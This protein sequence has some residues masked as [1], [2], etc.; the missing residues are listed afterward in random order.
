MSGIKLV[1]IGGHFEFCEMEKIV[2]TFS[3]PQNLSL[4]YITRLAFSRRS[5]NGVR[6]G[7]SLRRPHDLNAWNRLLLGKCS[8]LSIVFRLSQTPSPYPWSRLSSRS[9][10]SWPQNSKW[11]PKKFHLSIKVACVAGVRKGRE[12]EL[13]PPRS[14]TP[15]ISPFPSP[16][17]ACHAGYE[18]EVRPPSLFIT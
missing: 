18:K 1:F 8:D 7:I 12:R 5:D 11:P 4:H 6:R 3:S 16:F 10:T 14:R 13:G 17:N 15:Q 2:G 9:L